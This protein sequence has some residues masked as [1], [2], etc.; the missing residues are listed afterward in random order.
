MQPGNTAAEI[1]AR[2][3]RS[4]PDNLLAAL[5]EELARLHEANQ[6]AF[7][8]IA[9]LE[10][11]QTI[12]DQVLDSDPS[13]TSELAQSL[14]VDAAFSLNADNG[15]YRLEY[16]SHGAAYRWTGPEPTFYFEL[17][18]DRSSPAFLSLRFL[19]IFMAPSPEKVL[20]CFVDGQPV[21][22]QTRPID[23]EFELNAVIP[24]RKTKG[25]SVISFL[26][27]SVQ[28][29]QTAGVSQDRRRLG[30]A[31]RWLKI[32]RATVEQSTAPDV[33]AAGARPKQSEDVVKLE[34]VQRGSAAKPIS[35]DES[36]TKLNHS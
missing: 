14:C 35:P 34:L 36:I 5:T 6:A 21:V 15:F 2:L 10:I 3:D 19:K 32:E 17:L 1:L 20:R 31:F 22:V 28:S 13:V 18:L 27:P 29:P 7:A 9:A 8:R 11:F 12:S 16:D 23:G 4:S 25:G 26:C 30:L 24:Q 33:N